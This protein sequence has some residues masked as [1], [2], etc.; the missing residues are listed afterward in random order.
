MLTTDPPVLAQKYRL[1]RQLEVGGMGSVWLAEHVHLGSLVAVKL[2]GRE[3]AAT[4]IGTQRF[5]RE[6]RTAASLRSPN[7][8]QIL[9]YGVHDGT[10]FIAMELLEGESLAARIDR[11]GRFQSW[12]RA[13]RVL[14]QVARAVGRAHDAG[15]IHRDLKP[16]NVFLV[17]DEE[18]ELVKLLDFGIA[19]TTLEQLN[20][21]GAETRTGE[22]L[23]SPTYSSPEQLQ[24]SK[25][26]DHRADIWSFGVIAYECLLGDPPFVSETLVGLVLEICSHP[27]PIPSQKG[28]VPAGFDAWFARACARELGQRFPDIR[29]ASAEL[30]RLIAAAGAVPASPSEVPPSPSATSPSPSAPPTSSAWPPAPV[31]A[32]E[33][34]QPTSVL[35]FAPAAPAPAALALPPWVLLP[36]P[37]AAPPSARTAPTVRQPG[38]GALLRARFGTALAR[39]SEPSA[40]RHDAP[41][42]ERWSE[43]R[44][45][46]LLLT[47]LTLLAV[48][49]FWFALRAPGS[50]AGFEPPVE[51]RLEDR[52]DER[53]LGL[54]P[55]TPIELPRSELLAPNEVAALS[56]AP[57]SPLAAPSD[58]PSP[59][60][61][62]LRDP[63]G[64]ESAPGELPSPPLAAPNDAPSPAAAALRAPPVPAGE[65]ARSVEPARSASTKPAGSAKAGASAKPAGS[66]KPA[67]SA[68]AK[69]AGS[70]QSAPSAEPPASAPPPSAA[71]ASNDASPASDSAARPLEPP[72][73]APPAPAPSPSAPSASATAP[74]ARAPAS[75]HQGRLTLT[76]S[77]PSTVLLDGKPLGMTPLADVSVAPGVHE[78]TF[79]SDGERSAQKVEIR[80]GEHKRV[81]AGPES[82]QGDGLDEAAVQRTLRDYGPS[83]RDICWERALRGRPP[84]AAPT[85]VRVSARITVAPSGRVR[86]VTTSGAPAEYPDLSRCIAEKVRAWSFPRALAETVVNVPFVFVDG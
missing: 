8:V 72:P 61:A 18:E 7:V 84:A 80:A 41:S 76:A 70:A 66:A 74:S 5:L 21:P 27:L 69:S 59:L 36:E 45:P 83:V 19:K 86:S 67:R 68:S 46:A 32:S 28:P 34:P 85:S 54:A 1:I 64:G 4:A 79:S 51:A 50:P 53:V 52:V 75:R 11:D 73:A 15:I 39:R 17:R 31:S 26:L 33:V 16:A 77:T 24:V 58:L 38:R 9:D 6:A 29:E 2:M 30:R 12:E 40:A 71:V 60:V 56:D 48:P 63:P 14:R 37:S 13:E 62:P 22:F 49:L 81:H 78:I 42:S 43:R 57:P 23:G 55:P 3:V 10:P 47:G 44:M 82:S 25:T 20:V 35:P 65:S